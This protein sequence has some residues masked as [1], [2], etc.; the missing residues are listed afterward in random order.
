MYWTFSFSEAEGDCL[1]SI[2]TAKVFIDDILVFSP[3]TGSHV[4]HLK[5]VFQRLRESKL[6]LR[7]SKCCLTKSSLCNLGCVFSVRRMRPD[8]SKIEAVQN[9]L[10]P[11]D[12]F[13]VRKFLALGSYYGKFIAGFSDTASPL[14]S[15]LEKIFSAFGMKT[16]KT[17]MS[18]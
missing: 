14:Y 8:S 13:R 15:L 10:I 5:E 9:W 17:H 16:V 11:I 2:D 12:V 1:A 6:M 4:N 7:G 3:G 18:H